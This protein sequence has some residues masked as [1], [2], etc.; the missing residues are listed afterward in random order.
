MTAGHDHQERPERLRL[1]EHAFRQPSQPGRR[2]Q[3]QAEPGHHTQENHG[4]PDRYPGAQGPRHGRAATGSGRRPYRQCGDPGRRPHDVRYRG[5]VSQVHRER[6][7]EGACDSP[8]HQ[9][10]PPC[11][12]GRPQ[13]QPGHDVTHAGHHEHQ[14]HQPPVGGTNPGESA[15]RAGH[16]IVR[17]RLKG[18][19]D[20]PPGSQQDRQRGGRHNAPPRHVSCSHDLIHPAAVTSAAAMRER[21]GSAG[22]SSLSKRAFAPVRSL[23]RH[24]RLGDD[25]PEPLR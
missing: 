2:D 13:R 18:S 7:D 6:R 19:G 17:P 12:A 23:R 20:R 24:G 9:D 15:D 21:P 10:Q 25:E 22:P 11:H 5:T 1:A 16:R 4:H 8:A 14:G 3:L